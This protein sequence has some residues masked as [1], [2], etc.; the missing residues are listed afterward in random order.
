MR[1]QKLKLED[2]QSSH[3]L[4]GPALGYPIIVTWSHPPIEFVSVIYNLYQDWPSIFKLIQCYNLDE[5]GIIFRFDVRVKHRTMTDWL[6]YTTW[7]PEVRN[8]GRLHESRAQRER[9]RKREGERERESEGEREGEREGEGERDF[10][11]REVEIGE[12]GEKEEE[13]YMW[14]IIT[15]TVRSTENTY[16]WVS[17]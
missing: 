14:F 16:K 10:L 15:G 5:D 1:D 2:L 17:V 4:G 12:E 11:D 3:T 7:T 13:I 6:D 9:E 8:I